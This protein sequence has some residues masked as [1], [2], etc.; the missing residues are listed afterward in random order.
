VGND[1]L[2]LDPTNTPLSPDEQEGLIPSLATQ[3]ELNE[4][5]RENILA[6]RTWALSEKELRRCDPVNESYIRELHRRMFGDT[7]KWAGTYRRT[8]KNLGVLAH[9]IRERIAVLLGD[10]RYWISHQTYQ[11]DEIAIRTHHQLTRIHPFPNGNGRHARLFADVVAVKLGRPEF[12]WGRAEMVAPGPARAAYIG[13]LKLA[14]A[15]N[16]QD[17]LRFSRL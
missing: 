9:E 4:W 16:I 13:A 8:E 11:V 6:A 5:E 1:P 3:A 7:W 2:P 17:L 14:D 12:T 15:G 10:V